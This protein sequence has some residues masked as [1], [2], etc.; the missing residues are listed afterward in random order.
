MITTRKKSG[1]PVEHFPKLMISDMGTVVL[2][3][4]EET[5]T[6]VHRGDSN[7]RVGDFS[8]TWHVPGFKDFE[9]VIELKNR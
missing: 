8:E 7:M 5:G 3:T 4:E 9:G 6:V 1:T 2:F